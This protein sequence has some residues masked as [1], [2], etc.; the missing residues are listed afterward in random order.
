[1]KKLLLSVLMALPLMA[2]AYTGVTV[3]DGITYYVVTKAKTAEVRANSSSYYS[4]DIVIPGTIEVEGVPCTVKS[5]ANEAFYN[6]S[7]LYSVSIPNTVE[8]IG[9]DAFYYCR[10]LTAIKIP[11]SVKT[12]GKEAFASCSNM[13]SVTIAEGVTSIGAY[14]FVNTGIKSIV[15]PNSV[16]EIGENIFSNCSSLESAHLGSG[17]T[18]IPENAFSACSQLASVDLPE[19]LKTIGEFAFQNCKLKAVEMPSDVIE[20][21]TCAF[22]Y[23]KYMETLK[24]GSSLNFIGES[25]FFGC[26][27]LQ[28]VVFPDALTTIEDKAFSRCTQLSAVT[29]GKSIALVG[30]Y[31][32]SGCNNLTSIYISDLAAW[33]KIDYGS[34]PFV[35]YHKLYLNGEQIT[36]LFI[37]AGIIEIPFFA[38]A[39]CDGIETIVIPDGVTTIAQSAFYECRSVKS[40]YIGKDVDKVYSSAFAYCGDITDVY[41]YAVNVPRTGSNVFSG[42]EP[43]Y[44]TLH[45]P[46]NSIKAYHDDEAWGVF[47]DNI[48]ALDGEMPVNP[49]QPKCAAPTI[50]VENGKVKFS[51]E[52]EG[53]EFVSKIVAVG[54]GDY[55]TNEVSLVP[56]FEV[57]V[58]A[59]ATGYQPSDT[60]KETIS[61]TGTGSL[62]IDGDGELTVSDI[63]KLIDA[64]LEK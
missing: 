17:I 56:T 60:V 48:V 27:S 6:C 7:Y 62:D 40:I 64:Y 34:S 37:P 38:F 53:A 42:D 16:T 5:I 61:L 9:E 58:Y 18:A 36:N 31:V 13:A 22:Q 3:V 51:S 29:F 50:A 23:C 24:L 28:T 49:D 1:M 30:D 33:C 57:T 59:T 46:A 32:F 10:N 47:G 25:A 14:A 63:T 39:M 21:G 44:A 43:E 54:S 2:N 26:E 20:I 35:A 4:G 11:G 15:V 19:A 55:T 45:V 12:I 52:T 8:S 41:C